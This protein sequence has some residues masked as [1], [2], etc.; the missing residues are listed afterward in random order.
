MEIFH[1]QE[2][3]RVSGD[4]TRYCKFGGY[5]RGS[6]LEGQGSEETLNIRRMSAILALG[7]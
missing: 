6:P 3:K 2:R 1:T 7:D 5:T 4:M